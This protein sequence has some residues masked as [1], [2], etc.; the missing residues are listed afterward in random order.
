MAISLKP[1][2]GVVVTVAVAGTAV[3][4]A[5]A[6]PD[7][8]HTLIAYNTSGAATAY[9][10]FVP[11]SGAFS[12]ASAVAIPPQASVTLAL[13]ALS[14]RPS[15]GAGGISDSLFLDATVNGTVVN[16][17]YVNGTTT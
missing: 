17:T 16:L 10:A 2:Q 3:A 4:P 1:A 6:L 7:N 12:T 15:G 9:L 5:I 13:G 8:C 11:T 14:Q